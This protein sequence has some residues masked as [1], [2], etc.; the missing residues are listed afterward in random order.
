M[1]VCILTLE[2]A[3]GKWEKKKTMP[4]SNYISSIY[5]VYKD[6]PFAAEISQLCSKEP[7]SFRGRP[8]QTTAQLLP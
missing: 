8:I 6:L 5:V 7:G 1:R 3:S 4:C 2:L